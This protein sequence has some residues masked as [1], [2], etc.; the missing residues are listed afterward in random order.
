ML[1]LCDLQRLCTYY[2]NSA[3]YLPIAFLVIDDWKMY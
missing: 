2:T 1:T 3:F